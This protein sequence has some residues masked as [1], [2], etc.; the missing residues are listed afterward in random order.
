MSGGYTL[1]KYNRKWPH[2]SYSL[3]LCSKNAEWMNFTLCN[4]QRTPTV[5]LRKCNW[6]NRTQYLIPLGPVTALKAVVSKVEMYSATHKDNSLSCLAY[7]LVCIFTPACHF[8]LCNFSLSGQLIPFHSQCGCLEYSG[9]QIKI[10]THINSLDLLALN[11]S[12]CLEVL[13]LVQDL[14]GPYLQFPN[15]RSSLWTVEAAKTEVEGLWPCPRWPCPNLWL[16]LWAK[17][18]KIAPERP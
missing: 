8:H 7:V 3:E 11:A 10:D 13:R 6:K 4:W 16:F 12:P 17:M 5:P 15:F 9:N 18:C 2:V 14:R 1:V